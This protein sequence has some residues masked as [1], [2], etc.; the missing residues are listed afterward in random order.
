M[1]NGT[2]FLHIFNFNTYSGDIVSWWAS[3][4]PY[5]YLTYEKTIILQGNDAYWSDAY[6]EHYSL[7]YDLITGQEYSI[8]A[9]RRGNFSL[10]GSIIRT[11]W[12]E[13]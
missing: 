5:T 4:N 9:V 13:N 2:G 8:T 1:T 6:A 12:K 3:V 10:N 11:P 7:E